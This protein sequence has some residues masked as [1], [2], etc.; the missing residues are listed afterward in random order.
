MKMNKQHLQCRVVML[1]YDDL[2]H[3]NT[4]LY[5]RGGQLGLG[6]PTHPAEDEA[7]SKF[8]LIGRTAVA[9]Y[10]EGAVVRQNPCDVGIPRSV[11]V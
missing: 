7:N 6:S 3:G 4:T 1:I 10:I 11:V 9:E 8:V 2:V 5:R